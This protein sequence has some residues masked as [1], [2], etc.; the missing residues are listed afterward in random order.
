MAFQAGAE[1]GAF[2]GAGLFPGGGVGGGL[3]VDVNGGGGFGLPG[4]GL[5]GGG[6]PGFGGWGGPY[7]PMTPLG[8]LG[9]I[10]GDLIVPIVAIGVALFLLVLIVLAVK[11]AL[12]WKLSV[13]EDLAGGSKKWRR[14]VGSAPAPQLEED[15]MVQLA[16]VVASAIYSGSCSDR[17]ICEVGAFARGNAQ[18][19]KGLISMVDSYV[20]DSYHSYL[21]ILKASAEGSFDCGQKYQCN[22]QQGQPGQQPQQALEKREPLEKVVAGPSVTPQPPT[23]PQPQG[24]QPQTPRPMI[25]DLFNASN[26]NEVRQKLGKFRRYAN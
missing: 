16:K 11:M 2:G 1:P 23:V 25:K 15:Y 6:V 19:V 8:A 14:E 24:I 22:P 3:N 5:L 9:G 13:L 17:M 7:V 18:M 10:K 26:T 20:P 21:D 4:L 12:A